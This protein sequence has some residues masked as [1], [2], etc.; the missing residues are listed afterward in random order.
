MGL[1]IV[2]TGVCHIHCKPCYVKG[3]S[4]STRK[5]LGYIHLF[6]GAGRESGMVFCFNDLGGGNWGQGLNPTRF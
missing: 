6:W 2:P 1:F 4:G 5:G 3:N